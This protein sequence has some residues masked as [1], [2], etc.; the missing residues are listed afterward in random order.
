MIFEQDFKI[1]YDPAMFYCRIE[2]CIKAS[3]KTFNAVERELGYPRNSL[4]NY[5]GGKI[6]SWV[7]VLE[8][9]RYF[10]VDLEWLVG[11]E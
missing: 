5:R 7:R 2:E 10:G 3:G 1:N 4:H 9:S 11:L 6:P 8:I